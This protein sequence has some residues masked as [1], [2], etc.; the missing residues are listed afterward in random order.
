MDINFSTITVVDI[1]GGEIKPEDD[2]FEMR[3]SNGLE[4]K[5]I[6]ILSLKIKD[7]RKLDFLKK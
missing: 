1:Y 5:F 3:G 4:I 7:Y 6:N 2:P